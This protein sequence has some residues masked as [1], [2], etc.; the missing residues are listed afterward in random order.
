MKIALIISS[1]SWGGAERVMSSMANYWA[2]NGEE[3]ALITFTSKDVKDAY[4]LVPG[5]RRIYLD[6]HK[7]SSAA[8][9]LIYNRRR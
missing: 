5:V 1:L 6:L 2:E 9:K 3:I 4:T 8:D 7:R